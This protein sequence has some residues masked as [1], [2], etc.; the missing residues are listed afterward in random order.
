MIVE[1]A[2]AP[3]DDGASAG[4]LERCFHCGENVPP[5]G[6]W[7]AE[8]DG[9]M[10]PMCCAGC[11]AAAL[12]ITGF[13]LEAYYRQREALA[14][15]PDTQDSAVEVMRDSKVAQRYVQ[16]R[17]GVESTSL[18]ITGMT[19]VACAWL[20]ESRLAAVPGLKRFE[21]HYDGRRA[22]AAWRKNAEVAWERARASASMNARYASSAV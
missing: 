20:I 3:T 13:G 17:N 22:E 19:C 16:Q 14:Q 7:R 2:F 4:V 1:P 10:R 12:A 8:I 9:S 5:D 15:R 11:E 21:L 6:N 18:V